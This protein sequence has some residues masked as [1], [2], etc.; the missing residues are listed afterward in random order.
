MNKFLPNIFASIAMLIMCLLLISC[1]NSKE[2]DLEENSK[3]ISRI[4]GTWK[5][6]VPEE[7]DKGHYVYDQLKEDGSFLELDVN[8]ETVTSIIHGSWNLNGKGLTLIFYSKGR[9]YVAE[10]SVLSLS[11]NEMILKSSTA[12]HPFVRVG[13]AEIEKF[14]NTD[15]SDTEE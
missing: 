14:L 15:S 3:I 12:I 9:Y 10:M 1:D 7:A 11:D 4:V 5:S 6:N 8:K 13:S 2:D